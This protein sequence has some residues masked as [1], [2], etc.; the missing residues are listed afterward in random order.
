MKSLL[1]RLLRAPD[2][3]AAPS[4]SARLSETDREGARRE[5]LALAL[6]DVLRRSGIAPTWIT[7]H[8]QPSTTA[9]RERGVHLFLMIREWHPKLLVFLV[10][11]ERHVRARAVRLDPFAAEW[12]T[13][14]S[15]RFDLADETACPALPRPDFWQE[16]ARRTP[17]WPR[18]EREAASAA[19]LPSA[20]G[21]DRRFGPPVGT[22]LPDPGF[23]PTEPMPH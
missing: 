14:I 7:P 6:H 5:M 15:W 21:R 2:S 11:I 9:R 12:L 8:P 23:L 17:A 13:G 22:V 16:D 10:A 18:R 4:T 20:P 19:P 1:N 3:Q